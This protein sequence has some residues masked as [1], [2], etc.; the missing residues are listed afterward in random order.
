M[1]YASD[2]RRIARGVLSGR[3]VLATLVAFIASLIGVDT[4]FSAGGGNFKFEA[5]E[6]PEWLNGEIAEF[7]LKYGQTIA[8]VAAVLAIVYLIIGGA[9]ILGYT[10]FNLN[11]VDGRD[12]RVGDL[13]SQFNRLGTGFV[14]IF[15]MGLY[16]SLWSLLFVIPGMI[17]SYSYS[18]T[19][20][21]LTEHPEYSV[22][23]AITESRRM[24][25]GNKFRLFCLRL[26][27][28]GWS[29]L[30]GVF[31]GI[32]FAGLFGGVPLL[33][34]LLV[35]SM[36]GSYVLRAYAEAAEAAFY[37]E[38]SHTEF[39]DYTNYENVEA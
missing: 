11:L 2:F 12:A 32:G 30:C 34:L 7:V 27:F 21:I 4:S 29:I 5:G 16:I 25:D 14:M 13:F 23:Y 37:R 33:A 22:N 15:L 28:I 8:I 26:S 36:I 6:L 19:R 20:Y 3:W 35:V 24:M 10:K 39:S 38:V 1:K 9:A 31:A 17:K 18:M